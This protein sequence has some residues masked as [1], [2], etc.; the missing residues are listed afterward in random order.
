M[1]GVAGAL[2]GF[3]ISRSKML[4]VKIICVGSIKEAYLR[5]GIAEYAKR[6]KGMASFSI[7]ELKEE[8]LPEEPSPSLIAA[9]LDREAEKILEASKGSYRIAMCVEA[10]QRT[11]EELAALIERVSLSHSSVSF[12]IGSSH[13]LSKKVKDAANDKLS[14]SKLTYPHQLMRLMLSESI[15]RSFSIIKGSKYH[16]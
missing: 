15:Y 4:E 16:K 10:S 9:A 13:G 2:H 5:D 6:L 14:V 7:V 12:I 11:S 1:R 3:S 8:R